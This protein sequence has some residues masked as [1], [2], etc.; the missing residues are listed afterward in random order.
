MLSNN[1]VLKPTMELTSYSLVSEFTKLGLGIGYVTKEYILDELKNG[2][3]IELKL[4]QKIPSRFIFWH[5]RTY[6]LQKGYRVHMI[7]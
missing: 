7:F 6:H 1:I 4:N 5:I 3:L 2:E